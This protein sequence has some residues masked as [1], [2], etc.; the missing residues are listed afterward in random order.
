MQ[1][2]AALDHEHLDNGV[3]L[4]SLAKSISQQKDTR[5]ILIHGDSEYTER[6]M[7]TGVMRGEATLRSIKDLNHRLITLFADQGISAIG[8]NGYQR[9][10]ITKDG[11]DLKLDAS[12]FEGL[13]SQPLLLIST[14]VWDTQRET[15]VPMGLAEMGIFLRSKLKAEQLFAFS[16]SEKDEIFVSD[17]PRELTWN[18]LPEHFAKEHLPKEFHRFNK[19]LRLANARDFHNPVAPEHSILI[20]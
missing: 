4:T 18:N 12:F 3:F 19:S 20:Q 8:I 5:P 1:Y 2:V 16:S 17:K 7:Q 13:P 11:E 6:V 14:L 9:N 15:P 10:F